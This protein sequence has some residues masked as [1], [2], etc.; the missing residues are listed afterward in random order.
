MAN[1][2]F[3]TILMA[4]VEETFEL[5]D[6]EVWVQ[7]MIAAMALADQQRGAAA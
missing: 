4:E 1:E 2:F 5:R 6:A 3:R 7:P